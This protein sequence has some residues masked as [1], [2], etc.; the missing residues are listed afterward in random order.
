MAEGWNRNEI[1]RII[2]RKFDFSAPVLRNTIYRGTIWHVSRHERP[3]FEAPSLSSRNSIRHVSQAKTAHN[4]WQNIT[5]DHNLLTIRRLQKSL[6]I[7]YFQK[8]EAR[9]GTRPLSRS[10]LFV[11]FIRKTDIKKLNCAPI[12]AHANIFSYLCGLD[13]SHP[14]RPTPFKR[15]SHHAKP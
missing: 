14:C 6:R 13:G 8:V 10:S 9:F 5:F 2:H 15:T 4:I 1:A 7:A 3:R 11:C 12:N